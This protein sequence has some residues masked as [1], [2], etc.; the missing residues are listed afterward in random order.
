MRPDYSSSQLQRHAGWSKDR[1][2]LAG[3]W[4]VPLIVWLVVVTMG[5]AIA[6][7]LLGEQ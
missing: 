3:E 5:L 2:F 7:L 4:L 1:L 6:G